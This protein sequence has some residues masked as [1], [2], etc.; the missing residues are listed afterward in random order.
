MCCSSFYFCVL[1]HL[2]RCLSVMIVGS[3]GLSLTMMIDD[4]DD[5]NDGVTSLAL[6]S[7]VVGLVVIYLVISHA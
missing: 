6:L 2:D 1:V 4:D 5:A 3:R 7:G